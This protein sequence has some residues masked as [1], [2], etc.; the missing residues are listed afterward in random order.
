MTQFRRIL[1]PHDFSAHATNALRVAAKLVA[2]KGR[3]LVLHV[4]VPFTPV[5]DLPAAGLSAYIAPDELVTGARAQ[6]ERIVKRALP[7]KAGAKVE[8]RTVI[9]DPYQRIMAAA[10]GTDLIVMSTAGR[11]GLSHLLIGSVAEK[12]VRHSGT[13]VLTLRPEAAKKMAARRG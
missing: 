2:P 1:V 11:T 7:G 5:T 8:A 10:R 4:V 9:G 6:L 3:I 12:V 13:P